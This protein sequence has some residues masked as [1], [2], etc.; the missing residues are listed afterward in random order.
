MV[1]NMRGANVIGV[2]LAAILSFGPVPASARSSS[3]RPVPARSVSDNIIA[4]IQRSLDEQR[5][6]D[7]GNTLNQVLVTGAGDPRLVVLTGE[8]NLARARYGD[9]LSSFRSVESLP[10]VR[11]RALQGAGIALSLLGRSDDALTTLQSAVTEDPSAW[12]AWS[13]IG[14][15]YD[16]R[17]DWPQAET[18]YDH[19]IANSNGAASVLNNRGFSHLLQNRLDEAVADFVAAL[20]KKPDLAPARTN[21]RLAI[22]MK[23]DYSRAVAGAGRDDQ[24]ALLNNAGFAAMAR[25]DYAQAENLLAQAMKAKGEFY[26]RASANLELAQGIGARSGGTSEPAHAVEP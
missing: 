14:A 25:G 5:Y 6:L 8:L 3:D 4:N 26:A 20:Q 19:A 12:R 24:A 13:A 17:R 9:A 2:I 11:A 23:G 15:E 10:A 21:L 7:A 16:R 22:A 18:A 1:E